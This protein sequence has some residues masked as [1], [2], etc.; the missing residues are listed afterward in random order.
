MGTLEE[1]NP[2][3]WP[4]IDP[5]VY[6]ANQ[7]GSTDLKYG[8]RDNLPKIRVPKGYLFAMGDN[9]DNSAD[10]RFWGFLPMDHLR[11][12]PFIVWWSFREGG[13]D[14]TNAKVPEGPMDVA[15]NFWDGARHFWVWSRWNRTGYI[16]R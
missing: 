10:S 8:Y 15:M 16:P 9:R 14:E 3:L 4:Y 1:S 11:G 6:C 2:S 12:R 13:N 5:E 7:Q